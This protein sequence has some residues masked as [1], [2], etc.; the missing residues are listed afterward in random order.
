M[1]STLEDLKKAKELIELA[2]KIEPEMRLKN[3]A[4]KFLVLLNLDNVSEALSEQAYRTD[5]R[6]NERKIWKYKAMR[7]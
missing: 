3:K 2:L 6:T 7:R 4:P 5:V 1:A